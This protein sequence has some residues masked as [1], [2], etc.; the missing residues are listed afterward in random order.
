MVAI[1]RALLAQ[2][3]G[4]LRVSFRSYWHPIV[5]VGGVLQTALYCDFFYYY[6]TAKSKV[7]TP[8]Y[9]LRHFLYTSFCSTGAWKD[10][11]VRHLLPASL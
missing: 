2:P 1:L 11:K 7:R 10:G 6:I 3:R 9:V 8:T 4:R 5:V